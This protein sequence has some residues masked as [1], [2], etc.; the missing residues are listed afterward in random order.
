M[1]PLSL[2]SYCIKVREKAGEVAAFSALT[3]AISPRVLAHFVAKPIDETLLRSDLIK[4]RVG[5][6]LRACGKAP[7]IWDS[8]FVTLVEDDPDID[9]ADLAFL[10]SK[11]REFGVL[12]IPAI[13]KSFDFFR[14][15]TLLAHARKS[16]LPVCFV[17][18]FADIGDWDALLSSVS[19][20]GVEPENCI[21]QL[22]TSD[23]D[24]SHH[25]EFA[26]FL[27]DQLVSLTDRAAWLKVIVCGT[28]YPFKNLAPANDIYR[29]T[30]H[31][32]LVWQ[33]LSNLLNIRALGVMFGDYGA[34]HGTISY[35]NGGRTIQHL[36]WAC[37]E[38]TIIVRGNADFSSI[39]DV[40]KKTITLIAPYEPTFCQGDAFLQSCADKLAPGSATTWRTANMNR[41]ITL[42]VCETCQLLGL[43]LPE[44]RIEKAIQLEMF[45]S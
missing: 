37:G 9:A 29:V 8:Q 1:N 19:D 7:C 31:E 4:D 32:W 21:I 11:F 26:E 22:D 45:V 10:L 16:G 25:Q 41:H 35:K 5:N 12:A 17:V 33:A 38:E 6:L 13:H 39:H 2:Q 40:A 28:S 24:L 36:R 44:F 42:L 3:S 20:L 15:K 43:P 23:A 27:K 14:R 30:R 34:D 18:N